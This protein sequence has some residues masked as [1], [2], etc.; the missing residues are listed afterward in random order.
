MTNKDAAIAHAVTEII[1][2]IG[3]NPDIVTAITYQSSGYITVRYKSSLGLPVRHYNYP[4]AHKILC[5]TKEGPET[6]PAHRKED[7]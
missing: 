1:E 7:A 2:A 3:E 4:G 5:S 6:R